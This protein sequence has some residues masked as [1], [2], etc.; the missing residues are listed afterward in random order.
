MIRLRSPCAQR[1]PRN[2]RTTP[3]QQTFSIPASGNSS[4]SWLPFL[5]LVLYLPAQIVRVG[6]SHLQ[7]GSAIR[8]CPSTTQHFATSLVFDFAIAGAIPDELPFQI[9]RS[10]IVTLN[11][12]S[13]AGC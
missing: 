1:S 9:I 4:C 5:C 11:N 8:G 10:G 13:A 7:D 3:A 2:R 6:V 12:G